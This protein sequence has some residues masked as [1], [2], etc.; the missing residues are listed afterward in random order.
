M[1][2]LV[3]L[4]DLQG[5][6][7]GRL[8]LVDLAQERAEELWRY[9]PPA[10]RQ[11]KGKGLAGACFGERGTLYVCAANEVVRLDTS[12][13][14]PTGRLAQPCFNDLHHVAWDGSRLWI[15]NTGLDRVEVYD[16]AGHFLV[17]H[18]LAP[19]SWLAARLQG[20]TLSREDWERCKQ[21][22]WEGTPRAE[23]SAA[24]AP[25]GYYQTSETLAQRKMRDF[26]HPN[27][28]SVGAHGAW[29]TCFQDQ[30][31]RDLRTGQVILEGLPG[32]PHDGL[33][34][35]GKLWL[36]C[37]QGSVLAYTPSPQGWALEH[38]LETFE[39]GHTG[40]CRGLA[41]TPELLAVGLTRI[42]TMP[43]YRWCD[44][45]F[46]TTETS[47]LGLDPHHGKL[48]AHV[49]LGAFGAQPKVFSILHIKDQL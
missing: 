16:R 20:D 28:V 7:E 27:H 40:W 22:G 26:V 25:A 48:L 44:L 29:V 36:T 18:D 9:E 3:T 14:R 43:R 34:E 10:E 37:T 32:F 12:R 6:G 45:P 8:V 31:V 33:L 39:T 35:G 38:R 13:W 4:G 2:L 30:R 41:V 42:E 15:S 49:D 47:V 5:R 11:V 46:D 1:K 17:A 23:L 19:A 24:A 21:A